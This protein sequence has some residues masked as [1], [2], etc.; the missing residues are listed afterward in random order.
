[1]KNKI[2]LNIKRQKK[3]REEK[4]KRF[5]SLC[6]DLFSSRMNREKNKEKRN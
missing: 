2:K 6:K 4:K 3:K 1:M 5:R